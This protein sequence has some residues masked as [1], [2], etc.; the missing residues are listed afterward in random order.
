MI[1]CF[2]ATPRRKRFITLIARI[3]AL[4]GM[5]ATVDRQ[6]TFHIEGLVAK[7]TNITLWRY[8]LAFLMLLQVTLGRIKSITLLAFKRGVHLLENNL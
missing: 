7:F 4:L 3:R 8:V 6:C 2:Y 5:D 1:V